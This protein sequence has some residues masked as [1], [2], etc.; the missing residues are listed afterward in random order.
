MKNKIDI[1]RLKIKL[2]NLNDVNDIYNIQNE[3]I[4]NFTNEEKGYF[5]PFKKDSYFR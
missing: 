1:D 5:L 2:C 4:K 3:V